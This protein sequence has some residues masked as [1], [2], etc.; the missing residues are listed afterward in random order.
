MK[1]Y[2]MDLTCFIPK[3]KAHEAAQEFARQYQHCLI[4]EENLNEEFFPTLKKT[5]EAINKK[6]TRCANI[7]FH[8]Q[9]FHTGTMRAEIEG[10]FYFSIVEVK[11]YELHKPTGRDPIFDLMGDMK[12]H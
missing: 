5:V 9:E 12:P 3:N 6:F 11:R 10:N 8:Y 2:F 7:Y 1:Q 4:D